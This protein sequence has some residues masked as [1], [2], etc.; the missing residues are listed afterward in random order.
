MTEKNTLKSSL[1]IFPFVVQVDE[2]SPDKNI[3]STNSII[4]SKDCKIDNLG[5]NLAARFSV[6][7]GEC[8]EVRI[9]EGME[10]K[11]F[12][13]E[14]G[15]KVIQLVSERGCSKLRII[16]AKKDV[17]DHIRNDILGKKLQRS[18]FEGSGEKEGNKEYK[19]K[20]VNEGHGAKSESEKT[21]GNEVGKKS[22][23]EVEDQQSVINNTKFVDVDIFS[24]SLDT[25]VKPADDSVFHIAEAIIAKTLDLKD[26]NIGSNEENVLGD[27]VK[28]RVR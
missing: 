13:S 23:I 24:T 14:N 22:E 15:I 3:N 17:N 7:N 11:A 10:E 28:R 27:D 12:L 18:E 5:E 6:K 4:A 1:E 25:D 16:S 26:K 2:N 19:T 21:K 8:L 9:P 20:K